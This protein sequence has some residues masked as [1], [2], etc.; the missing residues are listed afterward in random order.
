MPRLQSCNIELVSSREQEYRAY[1]DI[2][3]LAQELL[4]STPLYSENV[5]WESEHV[6]SIRTFLVTAAPLVNPKLRLDFW[7]STL[8]ASLY[9]KHMAQDLPSASVNSNEAEGLNLLHDLGR[10]FAP[11]QYYRNDLMLDAFSRKVGF[12][13]DEISKLPSIKQMLELD[14]FA[15]M[16]TLTRILLV[17]DWLGKKNSQ[18]NL[19]YPHEIIERSDQS[20]KQYG[21]LAI[22]PSSISG[23]KLAI[24]SPYRNEPFEESLKLLSE[25]GLDIE[26]VR[27]KV[28][29]DLDLPVNQEWLTAAKASFES[30]LHQ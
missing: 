6:E 21:Y 9:A 15:Q 26:N 14:S 16:P 23:V 22:W 25:H 2:A 1:K 27:R 5:S 17:S 12:R 3:P 18:G 13:K 28:A 19:V 30:G 4:W 8:A 20:F 24:S 10:Y 7:E 29:D 11:D